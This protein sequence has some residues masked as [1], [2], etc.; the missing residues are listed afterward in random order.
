MDQFARLRSSDAALRSK[1]TQ[2]WALIG[3]SVL[4]LYGITRRSPL[5]IALAA[6]GG[7]IALLASSRNSQP[8]SSSTTTTLLINTTP[9]EAYQFWRDFEN[10]PRFM[11]RI[12]SVTSTGDRRTRWTA[13]GPTGQPIRWE[14]EITGERENEYIAW[15]SLPGSDIGVSGRVEFREAPAGR[16][17]I[18]TAR[19]EFHPVAG[20]S[21][22][23]VR[24]L[25]KGA[26]FAIRQD[27]RRLEALLESGEIPTTEGQSHGPRDVITAA[28]RTI[29]PARPIA[30]GSNLREVFQARK[31]IA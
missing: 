16:G 28:L 27:M 12:Q 31:E 13:I 30:P 19:L 7:T 17:T 3:G 6:G 8:Q 14:A 11:N 15:R 21:N 1:T 5:G 29:D 18:I 2:R 9:R 26:N 4:A 10:L 22:K 20:S 25:N 23:L 24:F